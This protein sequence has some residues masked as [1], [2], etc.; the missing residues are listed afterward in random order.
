M[1]FISVLLF[2]C[3]NFIFMFNFLKRFSQLLL[4]IKL[5]QFLMKL[6][7][8]YSKRRCLFNNLFSM[9]GA[10]LEG[11]GGGEGGLP[12]LFWKS[13]KLPWVWKKKCP[14]CVHPL[15]KF[16]I[17]DVVLRVSK[18]KKLQNVSMRGLFSW[19]FD[20]MFIEVP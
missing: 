2:S 4:F 5:F 9:V 1:V 19:L 12:A 13:K 16:A 3:N 14:D 17:Q 6:L 11:G 15:V 18:R 7:G 20:K 8:F 10:Q